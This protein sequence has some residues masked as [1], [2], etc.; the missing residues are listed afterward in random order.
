MPPWASSN[1]PSR[2][3]WAPVNAPFSWPN[4][5]DS[6]SVSGMAAT[7]TATNG[8][9]LRSLRWWM[10]RATSSLPVPLSPVISTVAGVVAI[11]VMSW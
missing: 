1:W 5:S 6:I 8:C 4:S 10:A 7:L 3:A 9:A 11:C 2:R